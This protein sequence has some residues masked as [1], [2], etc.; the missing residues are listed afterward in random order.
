MAES[1]AL[2]P[3]KREKCVQKTPV[4]VS[5]YQLHILFTCM[6]IVSSAYREGHYQYILQ[7]LFFCRLK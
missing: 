3:A 2:E 6:S 5:K 1:R 4:Q 7:H